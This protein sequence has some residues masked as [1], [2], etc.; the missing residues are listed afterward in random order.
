MSEEEQKTS[1]ETE[2]TSNASVKQ[3]GGSYGADSITVL[4]G[5]DAVKKRPGMYIG[6]TGLPGLH[7][8]AYEILDNSVDEAMA[9]YCDTIRLKIHSDNS[10]SVIDNGRGI[11][12]GM[13][14]K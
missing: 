1:G 12:V 8:L 11:P 13:H 6:S 10:V 5:L 7:H 2:S 3:E 4:G 14:P 9:G